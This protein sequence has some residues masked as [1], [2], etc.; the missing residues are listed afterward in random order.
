MLRY[1][2]FS[3][4]FQEI[5]DEVTLAVSISGCPNHCK[6]CHSPYLWE[7]NG[8][9]LTEEVVANWIATYGNAITCL[10][11]MGGDQEPEEVA[12]L[13][14]FVRTHCLGAVKIAWYSGKTEVAPQIDVN[15]FD[16]LKVGPYVESQ[17]GLNVPG[18]NQRLYK[19]EGNHLTD[20]TAAFWKPPFDGATCQ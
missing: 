11:F 13:A 14:G 1:V 10:C 4:V 16:Y 18:T 9:I 20:M 15:V 8:N 6:G 17:G 5:P 7:D 19:N 12:R 2:D 3:I